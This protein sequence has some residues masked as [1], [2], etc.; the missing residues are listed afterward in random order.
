MT[1]K[2]V[3]RFIIK[4]IGLYIL[5]ELISLNPI[6]VLVNTSSAESLIT[7]G[8][9]ISVYVFCIYFFLSK[10]ETII[11]LLKLE[12]G[13]EDTKI[14]VSQYTE[15]ILFLLVFVTGFYFCSKTIFIILYE[16]LNLI[17]HYNEVSFSIPFADVVMFGIGAY[18]IFNVKKIV[19]IL[20]RKK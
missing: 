4:A 18:L 2:K 5:V 7:L 8:L 10:T 12:D 1:V 19:E 9:P 6:M 20:V 3:F 17:T 16:L 11:S 13:L 14:E 15:L